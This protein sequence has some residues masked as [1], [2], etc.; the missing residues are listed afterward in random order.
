VGDAVILTA[1]R[2]WR[3]RRADARAKVFAAAACAAQSQGDAFQAA[4][5]LEQ[6]HRAQVVRDALSTQQHHTCPRCHTRYFEPQERDWCPGQR[7]RFL[8]T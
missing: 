4:H 3:H 2:R 8:T 6:M 7:T 5:F 1:I